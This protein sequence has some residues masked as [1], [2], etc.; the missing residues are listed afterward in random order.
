M[1]ITSRPFG[2]TKHGE[3]VTCYRL[4]NASGAWVE[5][6]DYGCTIRGIGVSD[7]DGVLR[8]VC[9]G[10]DR[11]EDYEAGDAYLGAVIGRCANRT[12]GARVVISGKEY[13]VTANEGPN[14]LH[15]GLR[16]FDK[17]VWRAKEPEGSFLVFRRLSPDGEEGFPGNLEV[18]VG[19]AWSDDN[20]LTMEFTAYSDRDTVISM[21]NH[22]YF[23]LAGGGVI[24]GHKLQINAEEYTEVDGALLSTGKILKVE[25]TEL[26]FR[27]FLP[28]DGPL[29]NNWCV[30]G[31]GFRPAAKLYSPESGILLTLESSQPGLQVYTADF[32]C[33]PAGKGGVPYGPR[34]G[35]AL[36]PQAYPDAAAHPTFPSSILRADTPYL[37][38]MVYTFSLRM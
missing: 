12:A 37:Q 8:D 25:G 29:D 27:Q 32:L 3:A 1:K 18:A 26:D 23:N 34:M 38:K 28:L 9:L 10:Y 36:E 19:Y 11:I 6:L 5:V 21:T 30:T 22:S 4:E 15:G 24:D 16:G 31:A 35:V 33:G 13:P 20:A 7:R 17:Y 2:T 14:Q